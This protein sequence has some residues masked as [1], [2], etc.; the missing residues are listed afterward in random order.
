MNEDGMR[1]SSTLKVLGRVV[2]NPRKFAIEWRETQ[3]ELTRL[4]LTHAQAKQRLRELEL[5]RGGLDRDVDKDI[6]RTRHLKVAYER[7]VSSV[8][9]TH[10]KDEAM[11]LAVGGS[12]ERT[13]NI[14]LAVLRNFGL[15]PDGYLIDVG[16]GSG[17][18]AKSLATYFTGHYSGFDVV[19]DLVDYA[20][21]NLRT[22]GLA[23]RG[24]GSRRNSR[25]GWLRRHGLLF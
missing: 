11:S 17:R 6:D 21:T 16:C 5:L 9:A 20:R 10:P 2:S 24:R 14:E 4:R 15:R 25:D 18:L 3:Q 12:F 19:A 1:N 13:G 8:R 23:F 22:P 7:F